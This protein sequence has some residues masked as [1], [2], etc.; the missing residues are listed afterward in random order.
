MRDIVEE[1]FTP[2]GGIA[3]QRRLDLYHL[4]AQIG[5]EFTAIRAGNE[6]GVL[7][8]FKPTKGSF[9]HFIYFFRLK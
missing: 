1:R 8:N 2:S 4:G 3:N 6:L 9:N 7:Q 5:E